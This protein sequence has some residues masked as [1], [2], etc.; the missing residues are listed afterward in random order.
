LAIAY[1]PPDGAERRAA[2]AVGRAVG[3]AV[4]RNRIRR[5][6]RA[7][8]REEDVA[9]RVPAGSYLVRADRDAAALGYQ[10]LRALLADVLRACA[11]DLATP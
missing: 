7:I 8:L 1:L 3:P 6:L 9:G 5:R 4:V 2:F 10:E 11:S